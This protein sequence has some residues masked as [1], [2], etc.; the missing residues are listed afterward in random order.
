MARPTIG[1][2]GE[3]EWVSATEL[4]HVLGV[5]VT[6][7]GVY[8]N[9]K[10]M[11]HNGE[12]GKKRKYPK[13]ACRTWHQ[14]YRIE[15]ATK[16]TSDAPT[17]AKERKDLADAM[18]KE[19]AYLEKSKILVDRGWALDLMSRKLET[20]KDRIR[21]IPGKYPTKFLNL[22]TPADVVMA[23][24]DMVTVILEEIVQEHTA[25]DTT[26]TETDAT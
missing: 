24:Q 21:G 26:P 12:K 11:P 25:L 19:L 16:P 3:E 15:L 13:N 22:T 18:L 8:G 6:M 2:T 5:T 1:E 20:I 10:G 17:D 4:A 7:I 9:T 14:D 23:L